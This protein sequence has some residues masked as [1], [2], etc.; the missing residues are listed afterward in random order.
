MRRNGRARFPHGG[1]VV[2]GDSQASFF[3][4]ILL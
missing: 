4:E 1:L 3:T 2:R